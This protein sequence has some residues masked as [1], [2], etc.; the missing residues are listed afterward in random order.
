[1]RYATLEDLQLAIEKENQ[2]RP[3]F[4]LERRIDPNYVQAFNLAQNQDDKNLIIKI[5]EGEAVLSESDK[6]SL[7][8]VTNPSELSA[9]LASVREKA[10]GGEVCKNRRKDIDKYG[11]DRVNIDTLDYYT[12]AGDDPIIAIDRENMVS[13]LAYENYPVYPLPVPLGL[14]SLS[15]GMNPMAE[16]YPPSIPLINMGEVSVPYGLSNMTSKF[17][18]YIPQGLNM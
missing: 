15:M 12:C 2:E 3:S 5:S 11:R 6:A 4:K 7:W 16:T 14:T 17:I 8:T 9:K 13:R 10:L 1:M 18:K